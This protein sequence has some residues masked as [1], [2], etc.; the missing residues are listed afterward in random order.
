MSSRSVRPQFNLLFE[1]A[2]TVFDTLVLG[3]PMAVAI[4]AIIWICEAL[5]VI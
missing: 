3:F 5:N 4:I 1:F 2:L